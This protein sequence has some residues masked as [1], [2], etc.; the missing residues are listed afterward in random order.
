[1][2]ASG[3]KKSNQWKSGLGGATGSK[4]TGAGTAKTTSGRRETHSPSIHR[5]DPRLGVFPGEGLGES[6]PLWGRGR[7]ELAGAQ[8]LEAQ[9]GGSDRTPAVPG[10]GGEGAGTGRVEQGPSS[11]GLWLVGSLRENPCVLPVGCTL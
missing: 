3:A 6:W 9:G 5:C 8:T 10:P 11:S 2:V 1:M 4:V 7:P